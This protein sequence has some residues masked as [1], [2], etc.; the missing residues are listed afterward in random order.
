MTG[1]NTEAQT[2]I[3]SE[4]LRDTELSPPVDLPYG[5][6]FGRR[7]K[8]PCIDPCGKAGHWANVQSE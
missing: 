7:N 2:A 6:C 1:S 5:P 3:A 8:P 4:N